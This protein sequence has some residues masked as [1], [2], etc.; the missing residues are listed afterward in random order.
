MAAMA[1]ARSTRC[2]ILPP[3]RLPSPLA[4][5]GRASSEYSAM[6]SLTRRPSISVAD[7]FQICG[8]A[9]T[10]LAFQRSGLRG[11]DLEVKSERSHRDRMMVAFARPGDLDYAI[12]VRF[13]EEAEGVGVRLRGALAGVAGVTKVAA[14]AQ[15]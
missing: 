8:G 3:S 5:L 10:R 13:N 12:V 2:M 6:D 4:S 7:L 14:L 1:P 9:G 11:A 15:D